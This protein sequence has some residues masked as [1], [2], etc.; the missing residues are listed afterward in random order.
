MIEMD[1]RPILAY[2][3]KNSPEPVT[4]PEL[5]KISSKLGK[6]NN[7]LYIDITDDTL[8]W[9]VGSYNDMFKWTGE[10]DN[11]IARAYHSYQLFNDDRIEK[12]FGL[13]IPKEIREEAIKIL[14]SRKLSTKHLKMLEKDR[15]FQ[16]DIGIQNDQYVFKIH[17]K[18]KIYLPVERFAPSSITMSYD[19]P[20]D[21]ELV[22]KNPF[23]KCIH[24]HLSNLNDKDLKRLGFTTIIFYNCKTQDE[25]IFCTY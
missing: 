13:D 10:D 24:N 23:I 4:I 17:P 12:T 11:E 16:I 19:N 18:T 1:A 20:I 14:D 3:L 6:L 22:Y 15:V 8:Q 21:F 7:Y 25:F 5:K 2:L 9:V